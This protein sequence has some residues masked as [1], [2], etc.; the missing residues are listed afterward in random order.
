MGVQVCVIRFEELLLSTEAKLKLRL[1]RPAQGVSILKGSEG[2][3]SV[4]V[5]DKAKIVP[6][7]SQVDGALL[8]LT[9]D[10]KASLE[11]GACAVGAETSHVQHP[12]LLYCF[13]S[14]SLSLFSPLTLPFLVV[15]L[16]LLPPQ[17]LVLVFF[18]AV[19]PGPS[20]KS[21]M[22]LGLRASVYP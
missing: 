6:I 5:G 15:P 7:M 2:V 14:L 8:D 16:I 3:T 17:L 19:V 21:R 1:V 22:R 4:A 12:P 18:I 9:E 11:L 20:T 10:F 13:L